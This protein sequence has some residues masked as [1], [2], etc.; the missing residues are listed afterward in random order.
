MAFAAEH[1]HYRTLTLYKLRGVDHFLE[2]SDEDRESIGVSVALG[3]SSIEGSQHEYMIKFLAAVLN[4][5]T[6]DIMAKYL[7]GDLTEADVSLT[8]KRIRDE[9]KAKVA[10]Y[11]RALEQEQKSEYSSS[12]FG[13]GES[14]EDDEDDEDDD[15][16]EGEGEDGADA[17]AEESEDGEL[18]DGVNASQY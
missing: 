17:E 5:K 6:L 3:L 4:V 2:L 12:Q 13:H 10:V 16:I 18:E 7:S 1:E 8:L 9:H 15:E 11:E 14:D